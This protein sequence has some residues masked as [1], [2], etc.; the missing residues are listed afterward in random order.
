MNYLQFILVFI[1]INYFNAPIR[2]KIND[3]KEGDDK[4]LFKCYL[5]GQIDGDKPSH[6][7]RCNHNE[8]RNV[9][10]NFYEKFYQ[11][12]DSFNYDNIDNIKLE[13]LYKLLY[14]CMLMNVIN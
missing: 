3:K 5:C 6:I 8:I 11:L 12:D 14:E 4:D 9:I 7:I 1:F 13:L 10:N 2:V